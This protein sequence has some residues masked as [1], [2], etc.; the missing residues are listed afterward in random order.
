MSQLADA[1]QAQRDEIAGEIHDRIIPPLYAARMLLEAMAES[2]DAGASS[3]VL[4]TP[5]AASAAR[6]QQAVSLIGEAMSTGRELLNDLSPREMTAEQWCER[7]R[8][9]LRGYEHAFAVS[10]ELPWEKLDAAAATAIADIVSEAIRNAVR[11]ADPRRIELEIKVSPSESGA[12]PQYFIAIIDDGSGFDPSRR[13]DRLG[14][15]LMRMRAEA[16]GARL[17]IE[18]RP[19]GPTRV[20]LSG[21]LPLDSSSADE[22]R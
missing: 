17:Q 9:A 6:L 8:R 4:H 18:S 10:G 14:L 20:L 11:H 3:G 16:I 21:S 7:I 15:R 19:G 1:L 13:S 12:L 22:D 2:S 5:L